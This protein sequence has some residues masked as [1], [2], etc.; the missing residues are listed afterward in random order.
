MAANT[1]YHAAPQRDSLEETNYTEAPP[2][3]QAETS[4]A[5]NTA[6][7]VPRS[8]DDSVPD[9]FKVREESFNQQ[10]LYYK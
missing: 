3:Y 10:P 4:A 6:F 2:S 5:S 1:K 9:D 8:E 7:G